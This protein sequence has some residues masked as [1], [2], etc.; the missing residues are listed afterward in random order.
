MNI[1][2]KVSN[3]STTL[4]FASN[5]HS[6]KLTIPYNAKIPFIPCI[7]GIHVARKFHYLTDFKNQAL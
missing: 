6:K 3:K 5:F 4:V 7:R 2:N 1:R